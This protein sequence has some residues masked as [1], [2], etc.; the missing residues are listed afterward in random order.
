MAWTGS[1][2]LE[3]L[4]SIFYG[5]CLNLAWLF[6]FWDRPLLLCLQI[7][8]VKWSDIHLSLQFPFT[9]PTVRIQLKRRIM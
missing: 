7:Q 9:H 5:V 6:M 8:K 3:V 4:L 2:R 1:W